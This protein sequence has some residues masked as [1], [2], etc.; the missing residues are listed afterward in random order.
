M[1]MNETGRGADE[2][3]GGCG[4]NGPVSS[5]QVSLL[6]ALCPNTPLSPYLL[7]V[8]FSA[9]AACLD[10]RADAPSPLSLLPRLD[11]GVHRDRPPPCTGGPRREK[12]L[13]AY[14]RGR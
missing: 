4:V 8:P 1:N 10:C 6:R 2:V 12:R 3:G 5:A 11:P 14:G 9:H 7:P 13:V